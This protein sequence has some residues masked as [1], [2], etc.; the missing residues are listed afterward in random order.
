MRKLFTI[1][2]SFALVF[3]LTQCKSSKSNNGETDEITA[4]PDVITAYVKFTASVRKDENLK[5]WLA[6]LNK[7][8][9]VKILN[10]IEVPNKKGKEKKTTVA[11]IELADGKQG[12]I[13]RSWLGGKPFVV[14][15]KIRLFSQP[16]YA[17]K[18]RAT[19]EPGTIVFQEEAD[20]ETI[21][22]TNWIKVWT[23]EIDGVWLTS[24][25]IENNTKISA[26]Q[27]LVIDARD[28]Q[29]ALDLLEKDKKDEAI[30][31]LKNLSEFSDSTFAKMAQ[32]KLDEITEMPVAEEAAN[33]EENQEQVV[34]PSESDISHENDVATE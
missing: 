22:P 6:T 24:Q 30:K 23:G 2:V 13:K 1:F 18:V 10:V 4:T 26:E 16:D 9:S 20:M 3:S 32:E 11:H 29:D 19:L 5:D 7:A 27:K 31:K 25:W 21:E 8:E 28:Y 12:Y 14:L 17:S 33:S 34:E 15:E